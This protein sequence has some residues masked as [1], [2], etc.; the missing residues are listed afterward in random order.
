MTRGVAARN[1]TAGYSASLV[2]HRSTGTLSGTH[3]PGRHSFATEMIVKNNVD[4]AT[5]A[6][7]GRWKTKK[8]LVD[9]YAHGETAKHDR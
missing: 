3:Q 6:T 1:R 5:T 4:I 9:H 7:K 2:E 8:M